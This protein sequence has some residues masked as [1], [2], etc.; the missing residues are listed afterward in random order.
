MRQI[1]KDSLF[2]KWFDNTLIDFMNGGLFAGPPK[3]D[4]EFVTHGLWNGFWYFFIV[5]FVVQFPLFFATGVS[6]VW[7]EFHNETLGLPAFYWIVDGARYYLASIEESVF[8]P[9]IVPGLIGGVMGL[10]VGF[11]SLLIA[12]VGVFFFAIMAVF[13]YVWPASSEDDNGV[14]SILRER[15]DGFK[16][17]YCTMWEYVDTEKKDADDA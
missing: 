14:S 9:L 16:N 7:N 15:I 12:P 2:Y 10:I 11:V 5:T 17:N 1:S 4:C 3:N 6:I 8:N 13:N